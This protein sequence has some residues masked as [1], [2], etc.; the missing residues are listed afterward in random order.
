M[1]AEMFERVYGHHHPDYQRGASE[2]VSNSA[3]QKRDRYRNTKREQ[4]SL[5]VVKIADKH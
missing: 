3:R 1:T 2:A 5:N 4:T